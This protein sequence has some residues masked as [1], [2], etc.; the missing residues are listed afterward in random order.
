M[1]FGE[2][3]AFSILGGWTDIVPAIATLYGIFSVAYSA[4]F[5]HDER[6]C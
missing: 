1:F 3:L 6:L 4:R 2:T 5:I